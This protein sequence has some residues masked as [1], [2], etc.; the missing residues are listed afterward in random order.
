MVGRL[1]HRPVANAVAA[2]QSELLMVTPY[3]IPGVEGMKLFGDLRKRDV[4][5]SVLTN[6]LESSTVLVAQSG[7]MRYRLPLLE[8]G[9]EIHEVRSLLGNARGSGQTTSMSRYGNYSLHAKLF[10]FD[11]EPVHRLDELRPALD[12]PQYRDR[13]D[14]RQP[15]ARAADRG[16]IRGDG[17]PAQQLRA[18][19]AAARRRA[20]AAP[21]LAHRRRRQGRQYD[22]EPARSDAQRQKAGL[23]SLLPLD[24]EL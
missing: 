16:A 24:D 10:V 23:L 2:V 3:F 11:R 8:E 12:A 22:K 7:Y 5:V 21:G 4:R 13:P 1:M 14:H 15:R 19:A 18:D 20:I 9:V 17:E 6:S